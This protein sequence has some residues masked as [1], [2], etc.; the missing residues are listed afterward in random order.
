MR[1][2]RRWRGSAERF[3]LPPGVI[4]T[5]DWSRTELIE[6]EGVSPERVVVVAP[7]SDEA[8]I[9]TGTPNGAA[10]LCVGVVA[11]HKGQDVLI[12]ALSALGAHR[13]WTCTI[14]GSVDRCPEYA[15]RMA[16]LA[17]AAGLGGRVRMTGALE[18]GAL[19]RVYQGADLVVAPSRV[20]SYGMAVADAL[21]RGIPV[22]ASQV[23][24]I[25]QAV[26]PS[27]AAVLVPPGQ[28]AALRDALERWMVDPGLR[29]RMKAEALRSRSRL[30][31][32]SDT[33]NR[34][35]QTLAG[36]G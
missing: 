10:L 13:D 23:G 7:G 9:A 33:A 36:V 21:R 32:W 1:I 19:Q 4:V 17:A 11:H 3:R 27:G 14:A 25:P 24:G 5:S 15:E 18:P 29:E 22:L 2:P 26:A 34:I 20:E 8:P 30:P 28:P 35:A 16:A 12:D 31:R 6:R